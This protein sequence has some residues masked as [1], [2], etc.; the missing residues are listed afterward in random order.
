MGGCRRT[1]LRYDRVRLTSRAVESVSRT[2]S[3]LARTA[4][5]RA[6][7]LSGDGGPSCSRGRSA[8]GDLAS[9]PY[10]HLSPASS[11]AGGRRICRRCH[12]T[13]KPWLRNGCVHRLTPPI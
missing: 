3:I 9:Y 6:P 11:F 1:L 12:V 4:P 7:P 2:R 8:G 13:L 5:N 10:V